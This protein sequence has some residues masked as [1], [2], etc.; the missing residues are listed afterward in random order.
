[1]K[2]STRDVQ[3]WVLEG[4]DKNMVRC[5]KELAIRH[6]VRITD[7]VETAIYQLYANPERL[8]GLSTTGGLRRDF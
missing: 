5:A 8:R 6:D 3:R 2:P 7:I 1:M 4:I